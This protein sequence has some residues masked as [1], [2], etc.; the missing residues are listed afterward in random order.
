MGSDLFGGHSARNVGMLEQMDNTESKES[1][2]PRVGDFDGIGIVLFSLEDDIFS[3]IETLVFDDLIII[4][5]YTDVG[6]MFVMGDIGCH[7]IYSIFVAV[8]V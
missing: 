8:G 2:L 1:W 7:G 5:N 6:W 3:E 4:L